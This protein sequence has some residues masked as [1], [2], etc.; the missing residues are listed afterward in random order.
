MRVCFAQLGLKK[1]KKGYKPH[2]HCVEGGTPLRL[3]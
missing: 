2:Q 1:Q 3:V